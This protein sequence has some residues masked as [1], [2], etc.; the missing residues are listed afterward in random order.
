MRTHTVPIFSSNWS[1]RL[2]DANNPS[3][4]TTLRRLLMNSDIKMSQIYRTFLKVE[5][6][7]FVGHAKRK[8]HHDIGICDN[9]YSLLFVLLKIRACYKILV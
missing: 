4:I 6:S 3:K 8:T 7:V 5:G 2:K 1:G 9:A